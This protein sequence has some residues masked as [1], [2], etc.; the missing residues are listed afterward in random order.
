MPQGALALAQAPCSQA[1]KDADHVDWGVTCEQ[2]RVRASLRPAVLSRHL[3]PSPASDEASYITGAVSSSTGDERQKDL[4]RPAGI[5]TVASI[6]ASHGGQRS[7]R[8]GTSLIFG[9][10][11]A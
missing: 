8:P 10:R 5:R 1:A 3:D 7:A 2:C 9:A 6:R 11:G 4:F